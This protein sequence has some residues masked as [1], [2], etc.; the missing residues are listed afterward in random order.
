MG[1]SALVPLM[2]MGL[3][4]VEVGTA[5]FSSGWLP[6]LW[7]RG[8]VDVGCILVSSWVQGQCEQVADEP[9]SEELSASASSDFQKGV[10][11]F[12]EANARPQSID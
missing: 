1:V 5:R 11:A 9:F 10:R 12:Q 6:C 3:R 2:M 4:L 8:G 7:M